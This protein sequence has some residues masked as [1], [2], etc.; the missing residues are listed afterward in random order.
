[1]NTKST[2]KIIKKSNKKLSYWISERDKREEINL[3]YGAVQ[4]SRIQIK[5]Q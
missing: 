2:N 4:T 1:M 5:L 3:R